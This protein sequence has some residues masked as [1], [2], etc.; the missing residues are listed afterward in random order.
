MRIDEWRFMLGM[1]AISVG[2]T[3]GAIN[4]VQHRAIKNLMLNHNENKASIEELLI[5]NRINQGPLDRVY[6]F[7]GTPARELAYRLYEK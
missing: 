3:F 4:Y 2:T 6:T 7:L 5:K 1:C